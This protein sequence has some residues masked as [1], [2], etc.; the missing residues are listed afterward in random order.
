MYWR[1]ELE[2]EVNNRSQSSPSIV[3][4]NEKREFLSY[5]IDILRKERLKYAYSF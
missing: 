5:Q 1:F 2:K 4:I 3:Q